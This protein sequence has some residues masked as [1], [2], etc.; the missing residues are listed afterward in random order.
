M[1]SR[2]TSFK[3]TARGNELQK[4][5]AGRIRWYI[6]YFRVLHEQSQ[7]F[8]KWQGTYIYIY[9]YKTRNTKKLENIRSYAAG[10]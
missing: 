9:T 5:I 8:D 4:L 3:E 7:V 2:S 6:Y 1:L 10:A